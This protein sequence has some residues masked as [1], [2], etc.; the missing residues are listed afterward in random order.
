MGMQKTLE[1]V[2]SD[3]FRVGR[4]DELNVDFENLLNYLPGHDEPGKNSLESHVDHVTHGSD[5]GCYM[6]CCEGL[7]GS[8]LHEC[9]QKKTYLWSRHALPPLEDRSGS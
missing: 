9:N 1:I 3:L 7:K 8:T 4:K 5:E 2:E 6:A